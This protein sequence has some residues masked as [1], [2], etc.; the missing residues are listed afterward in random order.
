MKDNIVRQPRASWI[1]L[2]VIVVIVIALEFLSRSNIE[3]YFGLWKP[4]PL[5]LRP[6]KF[7]DGTWTDPVSVTTHLNCEFEGVLYNED[8]RIHKT[9]SF[10]DLKHNE[11]H[12][13][14]LKTFDEEVI[15]KELSLSR[16]WHVIP[17]QQQCIDI[18][19][20]DSN[21]CIL[22]G[23]IKKGYK[24]NIGVQHSNET[25]LLFQA[26]INSN[27][28]IRQIITG[29]SVKCLPSVVIIGFEK[30][31]TTELM[32]WLSYHP[33]LLSSWNEIRFKWS[34]YNM[35]TGWRP[36]LKLLPSVPGGIKGV[37]KYYTV[38]KS[39]GYVTSVEIA[40]KSSQIIPSALLIA[41]IRNPTAR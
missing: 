6:Y 29:D 30:C 40:K 38:D 39:P 1:T 8:R 18:K 13:H 25:D 3:S 24:A 27:A 11:S 32:L 37:G 10:L 9:F 23:E 35:T 5:S 33:N 34:H 7:P 15:P 2:A 12:M 17:D 31:S 36:Y 41:M 22:K 14:R 21:T 19:I 28:N 20:L 26:R 16:K 4:P